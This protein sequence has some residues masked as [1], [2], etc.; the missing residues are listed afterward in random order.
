MLEEYALSL[1]GKPVMLVYAALALVLICCLLPSR[2]CRVDVPS[3]SGTLDCPDTRGTH[4]VVDQGQRWGVEQT[5]D[6]DC[7]LRFHPAG[8]RSP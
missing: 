7:L 3:G 1:S 2:R 5:H 4:A 8:G 6:P